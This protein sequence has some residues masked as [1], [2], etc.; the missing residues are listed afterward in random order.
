MA[1]KRRTA[2]SVRGATYDRLKAHIAK[3]PK[4][5]DRTR[6][7]GHLVDDI[8]TAALDDLEGPP[9]PSN[10]RGDSEH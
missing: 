7:I 5:E 3:G 4:I 1:T 10:M 6:P 2:I 8:V 9:A